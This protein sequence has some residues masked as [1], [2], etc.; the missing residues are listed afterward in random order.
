MNNYKN[1]R[2]ILFLTSFFIY[3]VSAESV[4]V[5]EI[6]ISEPNDG[7]SG[8]VAYENAYKTIIELTAIYSKMQD[9]PSVKMHLKALIACMNNN[10][11]LL[12]AD[13]KALQDKLVID[14]IS[15]STEAHDQMTNAMMKLFIELQRVAKNNYFNNLELK[16][17]FYFQPD[18]TI[19]A[20]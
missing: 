4:T 6:I 10:Y 1:I 8:M 14:Y 15:S 16:K 19:S 9:E 2:N 18:K 3:Q 13:S 20:Q 12:D 7:T 17:Y 11:S 5:E